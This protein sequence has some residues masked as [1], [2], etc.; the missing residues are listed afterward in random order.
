MN[1][2]IIA[3]VNEKY[4]CK[5][6][7]KYYSEYIDVWQSWWRG[8]YR[9][10]HRY[11]IYNG[12]KL[13]QRDFYTLK[14]AKKVCEDWA[15]ILLNEKTKC[16]ISNEKAAEFVQGT[17]ENSGVFGDNNFWVEGNGLIEEAFATG[18][19]AV[20]LRLENAH[21]DEKNNLVGGA[22]TRIR[23]C[24]MSAAYIIPIS[25]RS[26]KITEAAFCSEHIV[27]G[28]R[29]FLLEVHV[30]NGESYVIRNHWLNAENE[31]I[32]EE[33]LPDGILS[34]FRTGSKVPWFS[35]FMPNIKNNIENN[36][37]M[38]I[39]ILHGA[40]DILKG[41]DLSYNNFCKDFELGGK[42]VFMLK[43]LVETT[44]DGTDVAPDDVGQQLF[45]LVS[46]DNLNTDGN[47][48]NKF[49]HEFN[50]SIRVQENTDGVQAQLDYLS[51]KCGLGNKHYQFN[52]GNVVTATQYTGDKQD[53]IQNAHKHYITVESFL[54]SLIRSIIHIG[55]RFCGLNAA[56]DSEI[57]I[58]FDKSVV[59]D[60]ASEREGD[61][62]DVRDKL[63]AE[64]EYR[65]KWYGETEE[66]ARAAIAE[67]KENGSDLYGEGDYE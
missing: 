46:R 58:V 31:N 52:S 63:M 6:S 64:W 60:E 41:V 55:N 18:T 26:G 4:G 51:F 11:S 5:I 47:G 37:G 9:P 16:I 32:S 43:D 53:L 25:C 19:G 54:L 67:I 40:I 27:K 10:F 1:S 20:T 7:Q 35:I 61:R 57:E 49:I 12:K 22:D 38:G 13:I 33:Q 66:D 8:Y 3:F 28:R 21:I 50:P 56:E 17:K 59:I 14:M 24:Y 2:Q 30:L 65:V 29:Y 45:I 15:S 42:K 48:G 36:G 44:E 62:Q 23:L 34:E 39:S